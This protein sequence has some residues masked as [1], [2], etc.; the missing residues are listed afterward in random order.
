MENPLKE[1]NIKYFL[2]AIVPFYLILIF[3]FPSILILTGLFGMLLLFPTLKNWNLKDIIIFAFGTIASFGAFLWAT[4]FSVGIPLSLNYNW[5][6]I[7]TSLILI[8]AIIYA[9]IL[10]FLLDFHKWI[11][12]S[13][14]K[15]LI[16]TLFIFSL[17]T[18]FYGNFAANCT[19]LSNAEKGAAT[20]ISKCNTLNLY[21][22]DLRGTNNFI[23][24]ITPFTQGP[25][26][27]S[28]ALAINLLIFSLNKKWRT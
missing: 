20:E 27:V 25:S 15:F 3:F 4:V 9:V 8:Y 10:L 26:F 6:S 19:K 21:N 14:K 5:E 18:F 12:L 1:K 23:P 7:L 2:F 24:I 13:T 17:I 22:P 16:I 11:I 28:A